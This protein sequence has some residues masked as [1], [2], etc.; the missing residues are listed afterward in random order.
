MNKAITK[1]Q[2]L[3]QASI[4]SSLTNDISDSWH[5]VLRWKHISQAELSRR[6]GITERTITTTITGQRT[7]ALENVVLLCLAAHLPSE[8][9]EHLLKV[10][11]YVLTSTSEEHVIYNYLLRNKYMESLSDIR[12]FLYELGSDSYL[13]FPSDT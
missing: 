4:Y 6:T 9:S 13:I 5:I 3:E 7:A 10:S 2:L 11:G 1:E 12:M 8:I